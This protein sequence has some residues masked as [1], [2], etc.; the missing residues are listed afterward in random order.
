MRARGRGDKS[1]A[2]RADTPVVPRSDDVE[3]LLNRGPVVL[4]LWQIAE[5]WPVEYVSENVSRLGYSAQDFISGRVSWPGVTHPDDVPRLQ[6]EVEGYLAGGVDEFAQSY[7]LMTPR[8]EV[9]WIEDN[10]RLIRGRGRRGVR[11]HRPPSGRGG[12]ARERGEFP[13]PRGER[14]RGHLH[15]DGPLRWKA[16]TSRS[17]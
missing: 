4:F 12:P 14:A 1:R 16:G 5:G 17:R 9:R 13:R 15:R 7:R 11:R 8:G 6:A 3:G 10:N 2:A